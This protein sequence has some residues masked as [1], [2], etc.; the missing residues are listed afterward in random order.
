MLGSHSPEARKNK[1]R[2]HVVQ[3]EVSAAVALAAKGEDS[4]WTGIHS[5]IYPSREMYSEKRKPWVWY[6]INEAPHQRFTLGDE[7]VILA[8]KGNDHHVWFFAS[9]ATD[10]VAE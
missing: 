7:I 9:H 1:R 5:A 2:S 4:V 10:T 8:A 6:R 3:V